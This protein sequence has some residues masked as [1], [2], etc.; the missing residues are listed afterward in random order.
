MAGHR[1]IEGHRGVEDRSKG[2]GPQRGLRAIEW[3]K[4]RRKSREPLRRQM[5][6]ERTE[7]IEKISLGL[8][9]V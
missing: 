3:E 6:L 9:L 2:R 7:A 8:T 1:G 5:A 4:G